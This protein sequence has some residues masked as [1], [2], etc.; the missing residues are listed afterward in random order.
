MRKTF[1]DSMI[2]MARKDE[3]LV[4]LIGDISHHLLRDFE[5]EFPTRFYNVGICEQAMVGLAA[6]LAMEGYRPVVHTIAPFCVERAYEQI[7]VDLC[8][9][10]L[11]VTIIS[12]GASFDYAHL[13]CTHHCYEDV[14]ILRPLPNIDIFVPGNSQEFRDLLEDSWANGR[15]KYFK[16]TKAAHSASTGV[17]AYAVA[18]INQ[19]SSDKAIFVNGHLL[20][21]VLDLPN[22]RDHTIIYSPTVEPLSENA[23]ATI[24]DIL[25]THDV[26]IVVEENSSIGAYADKIFD[27]ASKNTIKVLIKKLGIP[28]EFCE[29]YGTA[30]DHR[31]KLGLTTENLQQMINTL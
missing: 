8:Y 2:E 1:A 30:N 13:G 18:L 21:R 29:N 3:K 31:L 28:R 26:N 16:L 20:Q 22:W 12:V 25:R 14:S 7:K 24:A 15:P 9:Q 23:E 4:V 10:K 5:K 19:G 6:G 27:I 17:R 11:D